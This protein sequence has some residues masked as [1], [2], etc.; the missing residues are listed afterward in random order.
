MHRLPK[1]SCWGVVATLLIADVQ[2][3][4]RLDEVDAEAA[5]S[6]YEHACEQFDF[7]TANSLLA[8]DARWIEDSLAEPAIF[9]GKGWSKH[10]QEMKDAK[11]RLKYNIRDFDAHVRGGVAWL[12]VVL[13]AVATADTPAAIKANGNAREWRGTFAESYVLVKDDHGWKIA[14]GHASLLPP[15]K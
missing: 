9:D 14:L 11:V 1:S 8:P 10:W 4:E 13:D 2:A 12:T 5:V 15:T 7:T 6:R 3:A